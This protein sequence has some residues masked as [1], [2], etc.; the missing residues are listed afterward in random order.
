MKPIQEKS[1]RLIFSCLFI[2]GCIIVNGCIQKETASGIVSE[3]KMENI[4][5]LSTPVPSVVTTPMSENNKQSNGTPPVLPV[6]HT[7]KNITYEEM[8][9]WEEN[10]T[11]PSPIPESEMARIIFS[12]T[13]FMQN[14]EDPRTSHVRL[15]F[16][17]TWLEKPSVSDNEPIILLRMPKSALELNDIN[18]D[19][20]ML[21]V[22]YT[23]ERFKEF[24]NM[25]A[26]S[27]A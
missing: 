5:P 18:S 16:P 2:V 20:E 8:Q 3:G 25:T 12:K 10:Y 15:T 11:P 9:R 23:A 22:S 24:P 14:D 27:L 6:Y 4:T 17:V 26:A 7:S 13:W 21:T 19:P 1:C